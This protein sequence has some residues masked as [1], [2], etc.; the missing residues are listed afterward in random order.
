MIQFLREL[1]YLSL[2]N[3]KSKEIE[4]IKV[5]ETIVGDASSFEEYCEVIVRT[6][7][8]AAQSLL[9]PIVPMILRINIE[10]IVL[11]KNAKTPVN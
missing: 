3:N 7:G 10:T 11:D 2:I 6:M 8:E 1:I 4:G 5:E 9:L